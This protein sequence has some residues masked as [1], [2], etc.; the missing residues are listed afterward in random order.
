[1]DRSEKMKLFEETVSTTIALLKQELDSITRGK[2]QFDIAIS[3][4]PVELFG[5]NAITQ[6]S[7]HSKAHNKHDYICNACVVIISNDFV[8]EGDP[9]Q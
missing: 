3:N 4:I 5:E 7:T 6:Y 1:M 8:K 9:K 2:V